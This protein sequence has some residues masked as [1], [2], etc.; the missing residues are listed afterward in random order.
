MKR[1]TLLAL[2]AAGTLSAAMPSFGRKIR[3][4]RILVLGGTRFIGLHMT[5]LALERGHTLTFF[6]RGKTKTD[7]YPEVERI[8]GDRNGEIDG[9]KDREWDV[10]IDNSGY[11]PR[12]VR[13]SA[14]LLAPRVRQYVFT[15][16]ISVYPDF[17]VPRDEKSPVGK[18]PDETVE[19]V[20]GDTY[21]PLKALCEQAVEKALPGRTTII[22][23]GLIVGPDDNTDRFTYWPARAARGGEFIA[24]G[25]AS[26]PFQIIDARDLAAFTINAVEKN[27]SGT[28]NLVS[29]VNGFR[30]GE[31]TDACIAAANR[32]AKPA[33]APQVTWIPA[34]F[35]EEQKVEPWSE[36]PV[37]LPAKGEET[38][39]AG[40]SNSA[41]LAKGLK[42]SPL[43]KTVDDTLAW[44][45]SRPAEERDKLKSGIA[46][47]KEASVLAAW[48]AK[49]A[50][51]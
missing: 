28:F 44:H 36:M 38:A 33:H 47:D 23:P 13:L 50:A 8:Q 27:I 9:L 40:T 39:F 12:H 16:S 41:A 19:K 15:S 7:R 46:P 6:N 51:G 32:Q 35:L 26:D 2:A 10:V 1:R 42:I 22:R 29:N 18:L 21:G 17:S 30:F 31:L 4:L 14:E 11:V 45:L 43:K 3:P 24:P 34:E 37:W 48:K 25:A 20:D 5:A 49:S